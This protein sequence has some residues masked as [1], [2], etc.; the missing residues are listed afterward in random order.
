MS[1]RTTAVLNLL[2]LRLFFFFLN[3][4]QEHVLKNHQ[5]PRCPAARVS[6]SC[7]PAPLG[8]R[9]SDEARGRQQRH[10]RLPAQVPSQRRLTLPAPSQPGLPARP[11]LPVHLR[12][13][14]AGLLHPRSQARPGSFP[15]REAVTR[16]PGRRGR[17]RT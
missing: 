17:R 15:S 8:A 2:T 5:T 9:G 6:L 10:S 7:C 14:G 16:T 3:F 13:G 1:W 12:K 4:N 11:S